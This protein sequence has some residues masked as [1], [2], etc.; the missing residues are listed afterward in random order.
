M[1]PRFLAAALAA[2]VLLSPGCSVGPNYRRPSAPV[3]P[4][5]KEPPP[6]GWKI[7]QPAAEAPRGKWWQ[8]YNDPELNALEEQV[9]ISNQNVLAAE[10][11][12]REARATV[13]IA[14][15]AFFPAISAAPSIANARAS[16]NL[17][18]R[19]LVNFVSGTRTDYTLPMDV[20]YQPDVWGSVRRNVAAGYASAQASA[21]DLENARLLYQAQL[22]QFY[23][24]LHGLDA[25]IALLESA[26][27]GYE[28]Y[29]QLTKDRAEAG[30]ASEADVAQAQTQL[31]TTRAQL[32]DVGVARAQYEHGIAVLAGKPPSELTIPARPLQLV[33]PPVPVEVPSALL[34]RRPDIASAERQVAAQNEQIGIAKAA[35][36]PALLFSA[37]GGFESAT[38]A[39][40]LEWPSRFWSLGPQVAETLFEG[41]RRHAEVALQQAAYDAT[42]TGYRQTVLTAFQQVEDNLAALRILEQE[43]AA[44]ARAVQAAQE[45]VNVSTEQYKAGIANYLQVITTQTIALQ[46]QRAAVNIQARRMVASVLLIEALGGGWNASQLPAHETILNGR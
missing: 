9:S 26:T 42:V 34:E 4:A 6:Q 38:V 11:R 19:N 45:S 35:F 12:Y 21:A 28:V 33:P 29:L 17:S 1:M 41:G 46:D 23:I 31:E 10:A 36:F 30:V 22:A 27:K 20:S 25:E 39:K 5:F 14:R 32:I 8:I 24:E 15:S 7:A 37:T 40:L 18:A 3:S 44:E 2:L 16:A 43:A 13:R